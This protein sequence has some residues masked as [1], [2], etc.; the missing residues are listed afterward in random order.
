MSSQS[1][2]TPIFFAF[3]DGALDY[4]CAECTAL[5]CRGQGFAGSLKREMSFLFRTYPPL[6]AMVTARESSV[7][8]CST[9]AGRCYFLRSDNLCQIEVE[10]GQKY[11][12]G[13]C[14][15]FPFNDFY[16]IGKTVVVAPHYLCPLRL[17]LPVEPGR[18]EGT[19]AKIEAMVRETELLDPQFIRRFV[20]DVTLPAGV[21][22]RSALRRETEFRD[23]CTS[24]LGHDRFRDVLDDYRPKGVD[25]RGFRKRVCDVMGW[26]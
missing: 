3:P 16:R 8:T 18:A 2:S 26:T 15:L 23:R 12:P 6:A 10:N 11:K 19:H 22:E 5:C 25:L 17:R 20:T 14:L 21:G 7:V 13:V 9:P 4:V 1:V 24:A